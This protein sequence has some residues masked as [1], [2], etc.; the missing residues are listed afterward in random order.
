[1]LEWLVLLLAA[2]IALLAWKYYRLRTTLEEHALA[3]YEHWR[4]RKMEDEVTARAGLMHRE[5]TIKEEMRIRRDAIGKSEAV[6][7]G[8]VTEHLT[9]FF[10][11]FPYDPRDARFLGT[12]VDLIV[13]DGLSAGSLASIRFVEV[14][15]GKSG[16]LSKRERHV[17][18][19]V[20]KGLVTYEVLH[21]G[22][23]E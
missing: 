11:G 2:S 8:K 17:R 21:I 22:S 23:E 4:S 13:F 20:E 10:P 19:C 6:I 9:P 7:K 16:A 14:K 15:T 1:M 12:P 18:E 5:W 3:L